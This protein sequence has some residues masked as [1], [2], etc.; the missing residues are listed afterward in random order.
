MARPG[1]IIAFASPMSSR[2]RA[3]PLP[4]FTEGDA[5]HVGERTLRTRIAHVGRRTWSRA[6]AENERL[7][8][9][10][11]LLI[12]LLL[13]SIVSVFCLLAS[14]WIIRGSF[15]FDLLRALASAGLVTIILTL[16]ID[17]YFR[18]RFVDHVAT[19]AYWALVNPDAPK[20]YRDAVTA[21]ASVQNYFASCHWDLSFSWVGNDKKVVQLD[22]TF[23]GNGMNLDAA[24]YAPCTRMWLLPCHEGYS[25]SFQEWSLSVDTASPIYK[26]FSATQLAR[27][28][29]V[30][31]EGK[32]VLEE[33]ILADGVVVPHLTSYH[34][35]R[36]V[37][38][39]LASDS[40]WP[41]ICGTV[42][43][44]SV[45]TLRGPAFSDLTFRLIHGLEGPPHPDPEL[46]AETEL[47][48]TVVSVVSVRGQVT[49]V[50]WERK[51]TD[52]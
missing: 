29:T 14:R 36:K 15:P 37:R 8:P 43:I 47:S 11:R 23:T 46:D 2:A 13:L 21:L 9:T 12:E 1:R 48:R 30:D 51:T 41:L 38:T 34:S 18:R 31:V 45:Y 32:S 26:V 22:L 40:H 49:L 19:T 16:T 33:S 5:R 39:F 44:R 25:P 42:S 20:E 17:Q 6:T 28:V 10:I 3:L 24:G 4:F 35:G 52:G 50:A 7:S 27:H